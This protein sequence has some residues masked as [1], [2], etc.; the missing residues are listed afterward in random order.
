MGI[1]IIVPGPSF[2]AFQGNSCRRCGGW[3]YATEETGQ[4]QREDHRTGCRFFEIAVQVMQYAK[5]L[6][7]V[8]TGSSGRYL[9]QCIKDL[10]HAACSADPMYE[11]ALLASKY[12]DDAKKGAQKNSLLKC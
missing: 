5:E 1:G 7:R 3:L 10:T 9:R 8:A 11:T 12:N 4:P 2:S 6:E